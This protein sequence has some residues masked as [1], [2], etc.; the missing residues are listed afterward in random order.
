MQR[1]DFLRQ[2]YE[3]RR[4]EDAWREY[5]RLLAEGPADAEVHLLGALTARLRPEPDYRQARRALELAEAA[6]PCGVSLGKVRLAM[7]NLLR[8]IGDN[9]A[10]VE[11]YEAFIDGISEYEALRPV[12]YGVAHYNLGLTFRCARRYDDAL[13]AY[14]TAAREFRQ[15]DFPDY[16]RQCLQNAAWLCCLMGRVEPAEAALTEAENLCT[17]PAARWHQRIGWAYLQAVSGEH[18]GAVNLCEEIVKAEATAPPGVVSHAFWVA[19]HVALALGDLG[20]AG[21]MADQAVAWSLKVKDDVR[22]MQD[23]SALRREIYQAKLHRDQ[24]GA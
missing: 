14:D 2:L 6:G 9:S 5:H 12:C 20:R 16:L 17:T 15:N 19:G 18:I 13:R 10:A 8:E 21:Q 3:A 4:L 11:Y 22:P 24:T 23:A 1:S 7:G